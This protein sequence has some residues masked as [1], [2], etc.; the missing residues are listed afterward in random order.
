MKQGK[1]KGMRRCTC[2][3]EWFLCSAAFDRSID[4]SS[5]WSNSPFGRSVPFCCRVLLTGFFE[6][7]RVILPF[8]VI[9]KK[10]TFSFRD[11]SKAQSS[12]VWLV[13]DLKLEPAAACCFGLIY[14][15]VNFRL[16]FLFSV[17]ISR[18]RF[19]CHR[20][21]HL[22]LLVQIKRCTLSIEFRKDKRRNHNSEVE[23]QRALQLQTK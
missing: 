19:F 16:V 13:T 6:R 3:V 11:P 9:I 2:S 22:D 12:V 18:R 20:R 4:M 23:K 10:Q 14:R 17:T 7:E 21:T 15:A 1:G 8:I 5:R